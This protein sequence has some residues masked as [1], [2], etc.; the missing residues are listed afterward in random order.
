MLFMLEQKIFQKF[1]LFG[2]KIKR[3]IRCFPASFR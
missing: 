2:R 3:A 1:C